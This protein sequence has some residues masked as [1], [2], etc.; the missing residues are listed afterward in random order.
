MFGFR[1]EIFMGREM[2]GNSV[3]RRE[4][5]EKHHARD[6]WDGKEESKIY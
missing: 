4:T 3:G 5:E 2:R 1:T 6:N